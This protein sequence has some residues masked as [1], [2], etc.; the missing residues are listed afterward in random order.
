[1]KLDFNTILNIVIAVIIAG[2]LMQFVV[3]PLISKVLPA[4]ESED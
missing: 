2:L 1:M 3:T 4:L